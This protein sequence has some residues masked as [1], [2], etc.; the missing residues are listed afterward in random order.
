MLPF[1]LYSGSVLTAE[2]HPVVMLA[3]WS[4]MYETVSAVSALEPA[5]H[6]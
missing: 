5:L 3:V 6:T 1:E 2:L 4:R